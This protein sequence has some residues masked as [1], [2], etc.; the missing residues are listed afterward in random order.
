MSHHFTFPAGGGDCRQLKELRKKVGT[1]KHSQQTEKTKSAQLME[2]ARKR[3]ESLGSDSSQL[4]VQTTTDISLHT[5]QHHT[6]CLTARLHNTPHSTLTQ[7]TSQHTH[8]THLTE[9][10]TTHSHNTPHSTLTQ[11]TS[12]HTHT[13]HLTAHPHN[14]P[15]NTLT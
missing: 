13:T 4:K 9:H 14:T 3:E 15:H 2:E 6:T 1:L 7:H 11:H 5:L 8:T 10:L 12:Q